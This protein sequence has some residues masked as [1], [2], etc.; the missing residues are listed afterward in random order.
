MGG[1]VFLVPTLVLLFGANV[2]VA[3]AASLVA[4]IATSCG[5]ASTY[6]EEGLTDL[7][8]GMFLEI[9]TAVG[10]LVGALIAVTVLANHN[11]I[12]IFAFLSVVLLA[13]IL[14]VRSRGRDV[15]P[16]L[17][18]DSWARRL[19][20][21]GS[22]LDPATGKEVPYAVTRTPVGAAF[23]GVAGIASGLLGVGGGIFYVPAMNAFMNMPIRVAGATSTFMIG[24]TA[25]AGAIV[26]LFAGYL[27]LAL[28]APAAI[29]ILAGSF[30]GTRW[31]AGAPAPRLKT[32]F[33]GILV[34]V[35]IL[36][37]LRAVGVV[38]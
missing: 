19:R 38:A 24:V 27:D 15:R 26:F 20:L 13:A 5:S 14:M 7:R 31:A 11:G 1:G 36:M 17:P 32:L 21:G 23:A 25:V 22:Y 16:E 10:G 9:A 35:A 2:H 12:L 37:G 33:I 29:A 30:V 8:V 6:V 34:L 4:V 18:P 3:I 28:A